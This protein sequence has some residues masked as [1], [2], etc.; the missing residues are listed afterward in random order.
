MCAIV[1]KALCCPRLRKLGQGRERFGK[2]FADVFG[3]GCPITEW[4]KLT[5]QKIGCCHFKSKY[6]AD[7]LQSLHQGGICPRAPV[8]HSTGHTKI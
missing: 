8:P 6:A 2:M 7:Y 3:D 1:S 4:F 5:L